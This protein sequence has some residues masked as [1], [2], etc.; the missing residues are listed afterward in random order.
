[1]E[2]EAV[3]GE[4]LVDGDGRPELAAG[5][6]IAQVQRLAPRGSLPLRDVKVPGALVDHVFV[7]PDQWQTYITQDSPYYAGRAPH[8]R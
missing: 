3:Q 7:D 1:M 8:A 4:M 6:S 2:G 5:S